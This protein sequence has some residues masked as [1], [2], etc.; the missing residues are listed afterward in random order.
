MSHSIIELTTELEA[1][2]TSGI[3]TLDCGQRVNS[4]LLKG[5]YVL[6]LDVGV[7]VIWDSSF[8]KSVF[9]FEERFINACLTF[10]VK[11]VVGCLDVSASHV[12]S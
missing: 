1:S 9:T 4:G 3:S 5:R 12:N 10:G 6:A 11:P 8:P 7:L 2:L